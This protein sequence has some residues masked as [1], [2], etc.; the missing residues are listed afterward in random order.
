MAAGIVLYLLYIVS[1]GGD[2]MRGRFLTAPLFAAVC[3]L[4]LGP[5][6]VGGRMGVG[7]L[8]HRHPGAASRRG[9]LA[10]AGPSANQCPSLLCLEPSSPNAESAT[11]MLYYYR[12]TA[13]LSA[14]RQPHVEYPCFRWATS[15]R[16]LHAIAAAF[17]KKLVVDFDSVGFCGFYAGPDV[18]IV[19][20][21]ALGDPL[22]ARL[23]PI[24]DPFW[25]IGHFWR[26]PPSAIYTTLRTGK[27]LL[28]EPGL[29]EYYDHLSLITRG[30]LWD[31]RRL[32]A[33]WNMNLGR[34]D[35]LLEPARRTDPHDGSA[36]FQLAPDPAAAL[37]ELNRNIAAHPEEPLFYACRGM[38][39][40]K[41]DETDKAIHDVNRVLALD[42]GDA[43]GLQLPR[44][45]ILR[46]GRRRQGPG[47][48][49]SR[50]RNGPALANGAGESRS[51]VPSTGRIGQ[52]IGGF[53]PGH[54]R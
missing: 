34:Y 38:F 46:A 35:R 5:L 26:L 37:R 6:E 15:G 40:A 2:F 50:H 22:L 4:G 54:R 44:R 13:L 53:R 43:H 49:Q 33:I 47:R 41:Q 11:N 9:R 51:V 23:P 29:A 8:R 52:G 3:L 10:T 18:W 19:D 24:P 7:G 31:R 30:S 14:L 16:N 17:R 42:P 20:H 28:V 25:R 21:F 27:N 32:A 36:G 12:G 1:I 48:F 39:Y 45:G